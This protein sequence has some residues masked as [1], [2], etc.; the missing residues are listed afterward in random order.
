MIIWYGRFV[1]DKFGFD[2]GFFVKES[3]LECKKDLFGLGL[4]EKVI[5]YVEIVKVISFVLRKFGDVLKKFF[6]VRFF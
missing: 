3:F 4:E 1:L 5:K 2:Y 6:Y